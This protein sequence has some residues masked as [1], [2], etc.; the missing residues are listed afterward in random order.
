[1][2]EDYFKQLKDV[3]VFANKKYTE[4]IQKVCCIW[5]KYKCSFFYLTVAKGFGN[6]IKSYYLWS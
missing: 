5:P 2:V 3:N 6:G 1:M 4:N